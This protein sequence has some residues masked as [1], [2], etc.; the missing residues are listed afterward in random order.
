M[1]DLAKMIRELHDDPGQWDIF[2]EALYRELKADPE[3][4]A[5]YQ[6]IQAGGNDPEDAFLV[7][8]YI[9]EIRKSMINAEHAIAEGRTT[10]LEKVMKEV[11][12]MDSFELMLRFIPWF[13]HYNGYA[14][15][16][17]D[18]TDYSPWSSNSTTHRYVEI[19]EARGLVTR[20]KKQPRTLRITEKGK[21]WLEE[22]EL[23]ESLRAAAAQRTCGDPDCYEPEHQIKPV[24]TWKGFPRKPGR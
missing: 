11:K 18:I 7:I 2:V 19:M 12:L 6:R 17:Q 20:V 9:P 3:A 22:R 21:A 1:D 24:E 15:S 13:T 16:I 4:W 5:A 14:P 10:P 23:P 8:P